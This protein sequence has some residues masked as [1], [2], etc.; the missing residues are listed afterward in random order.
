MQLAGEPCHLCQQRVL[1]ASEG[2][3]CSRCSSIF[4]RTC[5]TGAN[6]ICPA[7]RETYAAPETT[8]AYSRFCPECIRPN[9]PAGIH[10]RECGARTC[11]DTA[12]EYQAFVAHMRR[13]SRRY[14]ILGGLELGF[15]VFCLVLFFASF[16]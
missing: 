7:C 9:E 2:T 1:F 8:F 15:A 16:S 11:W 3:W 4:H 14:Q 13:T 6:D 10:C 5:I 12:E